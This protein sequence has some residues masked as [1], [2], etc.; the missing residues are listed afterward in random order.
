[1]CGLINVKDRGGLVRP[2]FEVVS[3]V[4][5]VDTLVDVEV[6]AGGLSPF[7]HN[8]LLLKCLSFVS[9][10]KPHLFQSLC[11]DPTHRLTLLKSIIALYLNVKLG[12]L[13]RLENQ[14]HK[15]NIGHM[16]RKCNC[17]IMSDF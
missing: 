9:D 14:S 10:Y 12:H 15:K 7:L 8:K 17:S 16:S 11:T 3:L 4:K 1:M 2:N 13:C 5:I 6:S